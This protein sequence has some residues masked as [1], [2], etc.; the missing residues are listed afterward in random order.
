[1]LFINLPTQQE[2]SECCGFSL[3]AMSA[4]GVLLLSKSNRIIHERLPFSYKNPQKY[5]PLF[6][7]LLVKYQRYISFATLFR[8]EGLFQNHPDVN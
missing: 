2:R 6:V 5:K 4:C 7:A 3:N 8:D 1:M